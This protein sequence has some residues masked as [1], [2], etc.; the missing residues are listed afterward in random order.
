MTKLIL[1]E[2]KIKMGGLAQYTKIRP[3]FG[4]QKKKRPQFARMRRWI[5]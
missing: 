1:H 4:W 3:Q 2:N 5:K